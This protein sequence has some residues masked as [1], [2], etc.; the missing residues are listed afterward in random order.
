MLVSDDLMRNNLNSDEL[1][2]IVRAGTPP[3]PK[4]KSY[5]GFDYCVA[6]TLWRRRITDGSYPRPNM[7]AG[8]GVTRSALHD[9]RF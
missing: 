8:P 2:F 5:V 1:K 3:S 9:S 6:R 7:S 4:L